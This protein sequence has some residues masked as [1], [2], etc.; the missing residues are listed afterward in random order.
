MDFHP[1]AKT[2]YDSLD[3]PGASGDY[4]GDDGF[5]DAENDLFGVDLE[6]EQAA[7]SDDAKS[8][9]D[10][11]KA[12][13]VSLSV[14]ETQGIDE[15]AGLSVEK[16]GGTGAVTDR[17]SELEPNPGAAK[18]G[19]RGAGAGKGRRKE[20]ET[21]SDEAGEGP[22]IEVSSSLAEGSG[23]GG[24]GKGQQLAE[25]APDMEARSEVAAE[26]A[27]GG[28]PEAVAA[29]VQTEPTVPAKA[30]ISKK[31]SQS[32][33]ESSK[34]ET[35]LGAE[36]KES[37]PL[38]AGP[39]SIAGAEAKPAPAA[40]SR[41][42]YVVV[43]RRYRPQTFG[44]LVGQEAVRNALTGAIQQ[45]RVGHAFLFSGPRGTGKTST[46]R[47]LAKAL[48]CMENGPRPDPCGRCASCL[49]I[50]SGSSLDVIEIDAA[51]N[52]G[53]D[54]IR[55]LR[56]GVALAPFSRFKVYI[57][58]EVHMLS[59]GAFNAL[60]KTL[61]E[62][63]GQVVFVLA[64]T[65]LHKVPETII[66]RC[67]SFQFRRFTESELTGQLGYI[68]DSETARRGV[69]VTGEDREK[70]LDLLAR[71]ADGGMRDAQVLLD[72]ILVLATDRLEFEQVRRF[73]GAV[74][75]NSLENFVSLLYQRQ[76][77][78]LLEFLHELVDSGQDLETFTRNLVEECRNLL[79]LKAAPGIEGL[80]LGSP[81]RLA[82]A[83][84]V[85]A[86]L[87]T[88]FLVDLSEQAV[89]LTESL[90]T[91][92][93]PRFL[94]EL[95][96]IRLTRIRP[97]DDLDK[98]FKRLDSLEK[99]LGDPSVRTAGGMGG[100]SARMATGPEKKPGSQME[101]SGGSVSMGEVAEI[102]FPKPELRGDSA[103]KIPAATSEPPAV[104]T[105][106]AGRGEVSSIS[107]SRGTH[108]GLVAA[109][110]ALAAKPGSP[111]SASAMA[112]S[113]PA[114]STF[115]AGDSFPQDLSGSAVDYSGDGSE[116][117]AI[118][119]GAA[120]GA[121]MDDLSLRRMADKQ[122]FLDSQAK[123]LSGEELQKFIHGHP[124]LAE[125]LEIIRSS[126]PIDES[127]MELHLPGDA[128]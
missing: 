86:E 70:I 7:P 83:T 73:L 31:N 117:Q 6:G 3:Y 107:K 75:T 77:A 93:N 108:G 18:A 72:Q 32:L 50:Q 53:V 8:I 120:M 33:E 82:R 126:I 16:E 119:E 51:S 64:T 47:I 89:A 30:E 2:P 121:P 9:L 88:V 104:V 103:E 28:M 87:P 90:K 36:K 38:A 45:G 112:F 55:D 127:R 124:Q 26:V 21:A 106:A 105:T 46:A 69:T 114:A 57:I 22:S 39:S 122:A 11:G 4:D 99:M 44:E 27:S 71:T 23:P 95:F 66:S 67:Q 37:V 111:A 125:L 97:L 56:S 128:A 40:P 123:V 91:A 29:P 78:P 101:A 1:M 41:S 85:A 79:L 94:L 113:S 42:G 34:V 10:P 74:D 24:D 80:V 65:E 58:D 102:A 25:P 35:V 49:S 13:S 19:K 63:P 81:E 17:G 115:S 92:A 110:E 12:K 59:T 68:L 54:N 76:T 62:P 84:Q 61:E 118:G 20:G 48:N 116:P 98:I 109:F 5:F 14:T 43:A 100:P 96:V 15:V 60:L 52:T